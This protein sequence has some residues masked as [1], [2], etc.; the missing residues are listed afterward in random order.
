MQS[1]SFY[2]RGTHQLPSDDAILTAELDV[3][4]FSSFDDAGVFEGKRINI[5]VAFSFDEPRFR[6]GFAFFDVDPNDDG[7][8]DLIDLITFGDNVLS[9]RIDHVD[10]EI[11]SGRNNVNLSFMVELL[12][13]MGAINP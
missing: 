12:F 8:N 11:S 7:S 1:E 5:D 9:G 4:T 2:L 3:F 6:D 10:P 13:P